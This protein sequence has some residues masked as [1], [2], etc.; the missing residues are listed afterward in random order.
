MMFYS[1]SDQTAQCNLKPFW[2]SAFLY[3]SFSQLVG[4]KL[5]KEKVG[6]MLK[7][8]L[9][10]LKWSLVC[11]NSYLDRNSCFALRSSSSNYMVSSVN[12]SDAS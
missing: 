11:L 1:V 5:Q 9:F 3:T 2:C 6:I 7:T 12:K 8:S 4:M 10:C